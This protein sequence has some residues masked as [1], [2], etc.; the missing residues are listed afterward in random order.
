MS[1]PDESFEFALRLEA[2]P[3]GLE[4]CAGAAG[5]VVFT[6]IQKFAE[7]HGVVS[8]RANVVA[9]ADDPASQARRVVAP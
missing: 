7:A 1:V 8:Q 5:G 9:V 2:Q 3:L 6:T 4:T